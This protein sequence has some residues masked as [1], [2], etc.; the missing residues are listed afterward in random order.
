VFVVIGIFVSSRL[1]DSRTGRAWAAMREDEQVAE[2]M[3]VN[4]IRYKLLA[5]SMGAAVG[6]LSG[7]LFAVQIGSLAPTSFRVLVSIQALALIILGGLGSVRGVII[8][9][10]VLVGIPEVLTE[11]DQFRLLLYG[12][13]L[14]VM[15]I[16]R[17][18]GL[19]PPKRKSAAVDI[20]ET[21]QDRWLK[22]QGGGVEA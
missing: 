17:P 5:F 21:G 20:K 15:M 19:L 7:A 16:L 12:I 2:A 8:G 13:V 6:C 14:M 10:L 11:F 4:T 18:Q 1:A 3:G 9:A 22:P